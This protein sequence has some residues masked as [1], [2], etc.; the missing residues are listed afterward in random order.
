MNYDTQNC[1]SRLPCG[2]CRLTNAMC[3]FMKSNTP[4]YDGTAI[5]T[6]Y[7]D[8]PSVTTNTGGD[9]SIYPNCYNL[10]NEEAKSKAH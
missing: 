4:I 1:F 7:R 9:I 5:D 3:P 2:L 10:K 8:V 6:E